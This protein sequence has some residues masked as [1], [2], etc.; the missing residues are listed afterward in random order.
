VIL[1]I[2][3]ITHAKHVHILEWCHADQTEIDREKLRIQI[4][5]ENRIGRK[6]EA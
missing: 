5:A 4:A 3:H 6:K 1:H 2:K